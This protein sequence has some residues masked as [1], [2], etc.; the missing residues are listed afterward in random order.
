VHSWNFG[1]LDTE[2]VK[3]LEHRLKEANEKHMQLQLECEKYKY[4]W[5]LQKQ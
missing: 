3:V 2:V 5:S 4:N 1:T